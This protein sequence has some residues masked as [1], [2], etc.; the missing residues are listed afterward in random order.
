[1]RLAL[2]CAAVIAI[3]PGRARADD[4]G[5]A[6]PEEHPITTFRAPVDK[7]IVVT[8][9]GERTTSNLIML[10]S[11]AGAG[12]LFGGL[13]VYFNLDSRDAA[14]QVTADA[15]TAKPWTA[16]DQ[17]AFDRAH[18]SRTGAIICYSIGGAALIG[19]VVALIVTEPKEERSVI[20]P[21]AATP[22]IVPTQGGAML[23][24]MWSF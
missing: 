21:H 15:P 5:G 13:G 6:F 24:G 1:M 17:S 4:S 20:H 22:T 23:G 14:N 16:A 9:P 8:T 7:D 3:A 2:C 11:I 12:V 10:A 18:S 19:A